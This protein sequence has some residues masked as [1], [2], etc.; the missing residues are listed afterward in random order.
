MEFKYGQ[1][2]AMERAREVIDEVFQ[3]FEEKFGRKYRKVYPEFMEDAEIVLITMGSMTSTTR[4]FVR[5]LRAEGK[6]VGLLKLTVFRPF[7]KEEFK[8]LLKDA[9]VVAVIER[10]IS[11]GFGG[12]V[13]AELAATFSNM[14]NKPRIIDFIV[15][16]GGRDITFKTLSEVVEIAEKAAKGEKVDEVNWIDVNKEA[17]LKAEGL[18]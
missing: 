7:P 3:E 1:W 10:N 9:K 4:E 12:A 18:L 14:E 8:S 15:G 16:L 17:V 6:K 2:I 5:R 13:Y 11:F